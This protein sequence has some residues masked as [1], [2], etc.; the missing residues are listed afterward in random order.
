MVGGSESY[1]FTVWGEGKNFC[2][3]LVKNIIGF[4]FQASSLALS[5]SSLHS[6]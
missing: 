1:L 4:L 2:L 6:T 3:S 5:G